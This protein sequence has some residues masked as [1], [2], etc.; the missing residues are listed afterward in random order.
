MHLEIIQSEVSQTEKGKY[1]EITHTWNLIKSETEELNRK[2]ETDSK[3]SKPN[4]WI[5]KGTHCGEGW[6]ERLG[7]AYT[8]FYVQISG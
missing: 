6:I 5:P 7:L 1:H 3:T 4:L 2:T 8:H